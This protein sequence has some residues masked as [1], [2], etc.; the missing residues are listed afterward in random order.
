M[1]TILVVD[2]EE[3]LVEIIQ[4]HLQDARY[5]V[6]KASD[7]IQGLERVKE[8]IPHLI[9]LD[10]QMPRMSGMEMLAYLRRTPQFASIPVL[11]LT[12]QGKIEN[13]F[14]ADRLRVEDFLIKPFTQEELIRS[15]RKA[16]G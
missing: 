14:E 10:L 12:A 1:K 2:D 7:G 6:V 9:I 11:I 15:V 4:S 8:S 13:I 5:N 16:I 3:D